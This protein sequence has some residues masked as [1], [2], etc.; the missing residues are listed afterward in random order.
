MA[1]L[2]G[3]ADSMMTHDQRITGLQPTE[4]VPCQMAKP[5]TNGLM[6]QDVGVKHPDATVMNCHV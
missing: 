1:R 6:V 4:R 3:V 2:V 5:D